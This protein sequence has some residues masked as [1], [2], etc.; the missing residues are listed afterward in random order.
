[1]KFTI[2]SHA[3]L[4]VEHAGTRLVCDPWLLG[5]CY[6]RS[7]WNFPEPDPDIIAELRADYI[8]LTHLHWDH[9]HGP[10]LRRL[11]HP[12]TRVLIP[13]VLTRRMVEDLRYLGF[14]SVTE[15]PHGGRVAL[16]ADFALR[17]Y[18][19]GLGVD[20]GVVVSGGS[21]NLFNCNDAKFFGLPLRQ[22]LRDTPR[23]DF[24][25]RSHSS[26][27]PIP[28]CV[29][30]YER[31]LPQ[32]VS[33]TDAAD[34]FARCALHVGARYAIP[35]ASN[36]C[37]LHRETVR[38]NHSATT[39]ED[40][41]RHYSELVARAGAQSECVVMPPG[42]SWS[43]ARGFDLRPFDFASRPQYIETMLAR[44]TATLQSCYREE[45][46]AT[47]DFASF[48]AYFSEL[49]RAL[50]R[51]LRRR[52]LA[53]IVFRT[54]DAGGEY[55]W[56][57]DPRRGIVEPLASAPAGHPVL[58]VH[59]AVLRDCATKRMFSVWS[60]SKRVR[61]TLPHAGALAGLHRWL[62]VLDLYEL[63]MFPL[64]RNFSA[65]SLALRARRWREPVELV[66]LAVRRVLGRKPLS[67]A[68]IYPVK[69]S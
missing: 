26:A 51:L 19:F 65:R 28:Y 4:L 25:F 15:I 31:L 39:P 45:D 5:S 67:L 66:R 1:M 43:E 9:F 59:P 14:H 35:F 57:I 55:H 23:I 60:A 58:A 24:I 10:S 16:G 33:Q 6:W 20:S 64:A 69:A 21:V 52:L 34:Q 18:Q 27:A 38:F 11:F 29:E 40:V 42:S 2:L 12:A 62:T 37:F 22:I 3:G 13:K 46:A 36:H 44:H 68:M 54:R 48:Q 53:P 32:T 61:I 56:L 50:P 47:A 7:W 30:N 63:D 17:S 49:L 41:R 8:Y